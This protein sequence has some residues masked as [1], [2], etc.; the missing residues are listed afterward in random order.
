MQLALMV[1]DDARP[2]TDVCIGGTMTDKMER[3][4][5]DRARC[6]VDKAKLLFSQA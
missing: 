4:V 2:I 1:L 6:T 5:F 3:D